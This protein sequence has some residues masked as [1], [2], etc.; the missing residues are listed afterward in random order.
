MSND[1]LNQPLTQSGVP[2][3]NPIAVRFGFIAGF[4]GILTSLILYFTNQEYT[5]ILKWLPVIFMSIVIIGGQQQM[6]KANNNYKISFGT[7]LKAGV[8]ITLITAIFMVV[9]FIIY[10]NFIEPNFIDKILE[11]SKVEMAKKGLSEEQT[12]SAIEM[13]KKFMSPVFMAIMSF[14][15]NTVI[16]TLVSLIGAAIFKNEQ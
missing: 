8:I 15:S 4:I 11:I 2:N 10:A 3:L 9:Y 14:I 16:G 5:S 7:L 13:S 1:T 12:E 6:V